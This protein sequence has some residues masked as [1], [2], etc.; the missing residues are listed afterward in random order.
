MIS[1]KE[2]RLTLKDNKSSDAEIQET[3]DHLQLL[4]ELMFDKM[5][6]ERKGEKEK[7]KIKKS[8]TLLGGK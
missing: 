5:K 2:A 3:I 1:I 4:V 8:K 6:A 7:N